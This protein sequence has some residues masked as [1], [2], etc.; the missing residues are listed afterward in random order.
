MEGV[1]L[2]YDSEGINNYI[3]LK[4]EDALSHYQV[5]VLENSEVPGLLPV[6]GTSLNGVTTL[7]YDITKRQRLSDVLGREI[8]GQSAKQMLADILQT[9][10]SLEEYLLSY[11]RCVLSPEYM[12][13]TPE[14]KIGMVYLPYAGKEICTVEE[15]RAFYQG[16]LVDYL[17]DDNDIWFLNLLKY[18]NKQGFSL[19]G[20]WEQLETGL[21]KPATERQ[22]PAQ[23]AKIQQTPAPQVEKVQIPAK[24]EPVVSKE[25]VKEEKASKS[26]LDFSVKKDKSAEKQKKEEAPVDVSGLGFMVPGMENK[27]VKAEA[28]SAKKPEKEEKSLGKKPFI[29]FGGGKKNE[30]PEVKTPVKQGWN[31]VPQQREQ[32]ATHE[33]SGT[34]NNEN[35]TGTVILSQ[36]SE[37][38]V[39]MGAHHSAQLV[40]NGNSVYIDKFPFHIGNGKVPTDYVI[41]KQGV[42]RNH[43]TIHNSQGRY[44]IKDENSVNHT[45][46]NGRQIPPYTE[47]ELH[48]G[49]VIRLANEELIFQE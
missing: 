3:C 39:I 43:A 1:Q 42:S 36:G 46:V 9:L 31:V 29:L 40:Y 35:W 12:Y 2:F 49:D 32:A 27:A 20:L 48:F 34:N 7:H 10:L 15:I 6:H 38:T 8:T 25:P 45:F 26:F 37:A 33:K 5:K 16:I 28:V 19:A 4:S 41:A 30:E 18:V 44:Y 24:Q 22:A 17:T 47:T 11:S 21:N 13:L 23:Q 14:N